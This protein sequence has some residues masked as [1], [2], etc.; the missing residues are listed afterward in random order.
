MTGTRITAA[1]VVLVVGACGGSAEPTTTTTEPDPVAEFIVVAEA[2]LDPG[3]TEVVLPDGSGTVRYELTGEYEY[4][5]RETESLVTPLE[6][7]VV[8]EADLTSSE[9]TGLDRTHEIR[10]TFG[11][12]HDE[13]V[14][15]EA[16][17]YV[18]GEPFTLIDESE[19]LSDL[20]D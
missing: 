8:Y 19:W 16:V 12:Q 7:E 17:H 14:F 4:D 18:D 2:A 3:F 9:G 20:F 6:A 15:I 13:W 10:A 1:F 11:Y 5:V